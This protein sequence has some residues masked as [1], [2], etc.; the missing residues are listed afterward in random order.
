[1]VEDPYR[2]THAGLTHTVNTPY[3]T[4]FSHILKLDWDNRTVIYLRTRLRHSSSRFPHSSMDLE[5]YQG[6]AS[7]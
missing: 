6:S 3:N 1:M 2:R 4:Q 7:I 5:S